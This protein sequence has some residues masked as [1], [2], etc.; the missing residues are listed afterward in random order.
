MT[1]HAA[2]V[3]H[4]AVNE[5][6]RSRIV[7][8]WK[9]IWILVAQLAILGTILTAWQVLTGIPW[10]RTNTFMDPFFISRPSLVI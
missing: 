3:P 10:F 8:P 4:S 1:S 9:R 7:F 6:A 2:A 5:T